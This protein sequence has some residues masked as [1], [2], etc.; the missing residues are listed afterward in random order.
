MSEIEKS[1]G[2]RPALHAT[3]ITVRVLPEMLAWIDAERLKRDPEPS[4]PEMI[5]Q[6]LLEMQRKGGG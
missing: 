1:K 4:R 2:G 6:A 3:P 5:R